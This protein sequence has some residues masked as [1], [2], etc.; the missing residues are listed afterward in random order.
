MAHIEKRK[1]KE[2]WEAKFVHVPVS[3]DAC[4]QG[5]GGKAKSRERKCRLRGC[6]QKKKQGH[7]KVM[8]PLPGLGNN[9]KRW[10]K[11]TGGRI[12]MDNVRRAVPRESK[13]FLGN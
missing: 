7:T 10:E 6:K 13:Q 11:R 9:R 12:R 3:G 5:K 1:K 8:L 4:G 2:K